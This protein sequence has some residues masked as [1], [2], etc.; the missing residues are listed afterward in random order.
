VLNPILDKRISGAAPILW[1]G[2]EAP[3]GEGGATGVRGVARNTDVACAAGTLH[4][5]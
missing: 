5:I 4:I 3:T 1:T 2:T